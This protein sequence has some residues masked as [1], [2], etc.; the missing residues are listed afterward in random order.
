MSKTRHAVLKTIAM[1][2]RLEADIRRRNLRNGDP[3]LSTSEAAK[4]LEVSN[5][6]ANK[7][8]QMLEKRRIIQRRQGKGAT[9]L[10]MPEKVQYDIDRVHFLVHE[11]YLNSEGIGTDGVLLGLQPLLS[12]VSISLFFMQHGREEEQVRNL[13]KDSSGKNDAFIL[14]RAPYEVQRMI[15]ENRSPAVINGVRYA[16]IE[17]LSCLDRDH[18]QVAR[19]VGEYA[20]KRNRSRPAVLARHIVQPG[21]HVFFNALD[22]RILSWSVHFLPMDKEAVKAECHELLEGRS[23][24]R[25]EVP[26]LFVC[27]TRFHY[28]A[29]LEVLEERNPEKGRD[30][31]ILVTQYFYMPGKEESVFSHITTDLT[32]I[33]IGRRLGELLLAATRHESVVSEKIPV[34]LVY[35]D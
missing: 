9:V 13:L 26:D 25:V 32:G 8:L 33:D 20:R 3:F 12:S 21:D 31:D 14:V 5:G 1:A 28:E 18:V 11:Q 16:G 23:E 29:V 30:V 17:T 10:D 6:T 7:V 24:T 27:Q 35:N 34:H 22:R 19:L 4:V 2:D 15:A